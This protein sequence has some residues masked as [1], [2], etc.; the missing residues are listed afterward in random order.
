MSINRVGGGY[1]PMEIAREQQQVNQQQN[2]QQA[3]NETKLND[4]NLQNADMAQL[5]QHQGEAVPIQQSQESA[6]ARYT[7]RESEGGKQGQDDPES[8]EEME[9]KTKK[10]VQ[11]LQDGLEQVAEGIEQLK[12]L[13]Q[14]ENGI[15]KGLDDRLQKISQMGQKL[16]VDIEKTVE[17]AVTEM[18]TIGDNLFN[19]TVTEL[20][21]IRSVIDDFLVDMNKRQSRIPTPDVRDQSPRAVSLRK[22]KKNFNQELTNVS[23]VTNLMLETSEN[24]IRLLLDSLENIR[25][26]FAEINNANADGFKKIETGFRDLFSSL[27]DLMNTTEQFRS[28]LE[29]TMGNLS[30][31][32]EVLEKDLG[33]RE[34][35]GVP[36]KMSSILWQAPDRVDQCWRAIQGNLGTLSATMLSC[37]KLIEANFE[38]AAKAVIDEGQIAVDC[39]NEDLGDI[40]GEVKD[41]FSTSAAHAVEQILE[42][43]DQV[44]EALGDLVQVSEKK[45]NSIKRGSVSKK[46]PAH[47]NV[48]L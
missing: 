36:A 24:S 9:E 48:R 6:E 16:V 42:G 25:Q 2:T 27:I 1:S 28:E 45:H 34:A 35:L 44:E 10:S 4:P 5:I 32:P 21:A 46:L 15:P 12:E 40:K 19:T 13:S 39:V 29:T 18:L 43:A 38:E 37:G 31:V 47:F 7:D 41:T 8:I 14:S 11:D 22:G 20:V 26:G 30:S 3:K 33:S 17:M 23:N